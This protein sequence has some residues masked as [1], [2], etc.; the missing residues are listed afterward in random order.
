MF[1]SLAPARRRL[2]LAVLALVAIGVLVLVLA[3]VRGSSGPRRAP[4][5]QDVPG[6]VL[7]VPG[8]G[9]STS[10]L[11][12]LAQVLRAAG[13]DAQIVD[14]PGNALGDL[15]GQAEALGTA[16]AA[17]LRRTGASSVD[18]V[19]YSAGGV[20]ARIW[21]RN[22]GGAA[23]ARRIVTLGSPQHGTALAAL[24]SLVP[25]ACPVACQQLAPDSPVLAALNAGVETPPGPGW[26]SIWTT[27]DDVVLPPSSAS[28]AGAL[29]LTVQGVCPSDTVNHSGLPR[30]RVVQRMVLA[31][32][33]STLGTAAPGCE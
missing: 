26:V 23:V 21:A 20:V 14:L 16:V 15:N 33:G 3:T 8:Y 10:S 11:Q 22:H 29:D 13:R 2:V 18:V 31:A 32:L 4:V 7:L 24:G 5:A 30:D 28:L 9:G 17:T 6:P 1:A 19:G 27:H 12:P 25:D